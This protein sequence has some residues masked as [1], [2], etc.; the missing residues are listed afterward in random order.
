MGTD[1]SSL[2]LILTS[3]SNIVNKRDEAQLARDEAHRLEQLARDEAQR[4]QNVKM[5]EILG[6]IKYL[7]VRSREGS[8]SSA[9]GT[10]HTEL[11]A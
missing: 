2:T 11:S 7:L 5:I 6:D 3:L 8:I 4:E 10:V 1:L 9:A